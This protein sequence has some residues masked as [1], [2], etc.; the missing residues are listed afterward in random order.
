MP[1]DHTFF[2][3]TETGKGKELKYKIEDGGQSESAYAAACTKRWGWVQDYLRQCEATPLDVYEL[4][5]KKLSMSE[6]RQG[7]RLFERIGKR[8]GKSIVH[9]MKGGL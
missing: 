9:E 5:L 3:V 8:S 6:S 7:D 2:K 1:S 4:L